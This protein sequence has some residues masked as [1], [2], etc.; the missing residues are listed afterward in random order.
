MNVT[1]P[2]SEKRREIL[3]VLNNAAPGAQITTAEVFNACTLL[4]DRG[5]CSQALGYLRDRDEPYVQ[6]IGSGRGSFITWSITDEGRAALLADPGIDPGHIDEAEPEEEEEAEEEID[7]ALWASG[8]LQIQ[9][10]DNNF[11]VPAAKVPLLKR[12]LDEQHRAI[13][14]IERD[15]GFFKQLYDIKVAELVA[16]ILTQVEKASRQT[17]ETSFTVSIPAPAAACPLPPLDESL[18]APRA[19]VA[20][21]PP[22]GAAFTCNT[23]ADV[24]R[25]DL[26]KPLTAGSTAFD[27]LGTPAPGTE[28][29]GRPEVNLDGP[30]GIGGTAGPRE[31]LSHGMTREEQFAET[32]GRG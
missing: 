29:I 30:N 7:F 4:K 8:V 11:A 10:G 1:K 5:E 17:P 27:R 3:A 14:Q 20:S 26:T 13:E 25:I 31:E 18:I 16:S 28:A 32:A 9:I 23:H 12:Y 2:L 22:S 24:L 19:P 15:T 6:S 21:D